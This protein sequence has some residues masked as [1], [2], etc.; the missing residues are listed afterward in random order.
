MVYFR[1]PCMYASV[2]VRLA[3]PSTREFGRSTRRT[4]VP[5]GGRYLPAG[6]AFSL[7]LSLYLSVS[8][9]S[10]RWSS[11][12]SSAPRLARSCSR[13][14]SCSSLERE[15][16]APGGVGGGGGGGRVAV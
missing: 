2:V 8:R 14:A 1:P 13:D 12:S 7:S 6:T 4:G 11:S 5:G 16:V 3:G 10:R 9:G 15:C